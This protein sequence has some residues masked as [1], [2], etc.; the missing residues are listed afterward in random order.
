MKTQH[1]YHLAAERA[2]IDEECHVVVAM[3]NRLASFRCTHGS[4]LLQ[5]AIRYEAA[6]AKRGPFPGRE[7]PY[8]WKGRER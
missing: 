4:D 8:G 2:R 5:Q 3:A 7:V 1:F 6:I